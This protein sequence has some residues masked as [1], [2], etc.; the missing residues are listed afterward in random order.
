MKPSP[1][2]H[3]CEPIRLTRRTG[4][5]AKVLSARFQKWAR[6][7]CKNFHIDAGL[8]LKG[9]ITRQALGRRLQ[10]TVEQMTNV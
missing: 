10:L 3:R 6:L 1:E 5:L 8:E 4:L 9:T 7:L 2:I